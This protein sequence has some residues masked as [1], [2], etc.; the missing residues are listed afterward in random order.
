MVQSP[1]QIIP[2]TFLLLQLIMKT[3]IMKKWS[4]KF[5]LNYQRF[6]QDT[7]QKYSKIKMLFFSFIQIL[8]LL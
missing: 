4:G 6:N 1:L 3:Q 8:L 2:N 7:F 5:I